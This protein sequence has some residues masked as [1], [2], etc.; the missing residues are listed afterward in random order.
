[1]ATKSTKRT[2][3]KATRPATK[4]AAKPRK[5]KITAEDVKPCFSTAELTWVIDFDPEG[6]GQLQPV[7]ARWSELSPKVKE[8]LRAEIHRLNG[9]LLA[10]AQKPQQPQQA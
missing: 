1:M 9:L 10:Q 6:D 7:K 2:K 3:K 4:Q 8:V 5:A